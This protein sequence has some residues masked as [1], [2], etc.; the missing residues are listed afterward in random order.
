M[1]YVSS[2]QQNM[3][4]TSA[5]CKSGVFSHAVVSTEHAACACSFFICAA[6]MIFDLISAVVGLTALLG[7]LII[8]LL[9]LMGKSTAYQTA[10]NKS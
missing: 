6:S 9:I 3:S 10:K 7:M 8:G 2:C 1:M 5:T 4:R